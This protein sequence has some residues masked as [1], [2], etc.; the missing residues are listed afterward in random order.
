MSLHPSS[1]SARFDIR[2]MPHAEFSFNIQLLVV[3][4]LLHFRNGK[5]LEAEEQAT[6]E[7]TALDLQQEAV[8]EARELIEEAR[9]HLA[10][11]QTTK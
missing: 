3:P 1:P 11:Q 9:A 8:D 4:L 6:E 7:H 2:S 5:F 10:P